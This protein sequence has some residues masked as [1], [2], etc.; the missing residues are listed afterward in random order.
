MF[1][2]WWAVVITGQYPRALW[3]YMVGVQRWAVR[4]QAFGLGLTDQYPPF[5]F[6]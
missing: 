4:V 3:D 2:A 6:Q 1:I 5:S